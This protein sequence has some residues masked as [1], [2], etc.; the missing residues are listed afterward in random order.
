MQNGN[1]D[2]DTFQ[3]KLRSGTWIETVP[4][5]FRS[6]PTTSNGEKFRNL[7]SEVGNFSPLCDDKN[8]SSGDHA[9]QNGLHVTNGFSYQDI[10]TRMM[11][12]RP[13]SP[14]FGP[15]PNEKVPCRNEGSND[16]IRTRSSSSNT[17][18]TNTSSLFSTLKYDLTAGKSYTGIPKLT[19]CKRRSDSTAPSASV[20]SSTGGRVLKTKRLKLIV[21]KESFHINFEK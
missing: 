9:N 6:T 17:S 19:I 16:R 14:V 5:D 4:D 21:G 2:S 3:M 1:A 10:L 11:Q 20:K 12:N 15:A 18:G 13:F 7:W 8:L